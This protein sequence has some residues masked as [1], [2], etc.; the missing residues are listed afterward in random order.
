MTHRVAR[1]AATPARPTKEQCWAEFW[2]IIG[3]ALV[4]AWRDG[5]WHEYENKKAEFMAKRAEG[6]LSRMDK[7][8][9]RSA[10]VRRWRAEQGNPINPKGRI[11]HRVLAEFEQAMGFTPTLGGSVA[12]PVR[13]WDDEPFENG[14]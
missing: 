4:R 6:C 7:F 8:G 3:P 13:P 12:T 9:Y 1:R 11:P 2:E 14:T 10:D 5:R